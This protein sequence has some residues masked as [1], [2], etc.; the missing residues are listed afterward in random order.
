MKIQLASDL[1]LEFLGSRYPQAVADERIIGHP[2]RD[3]L[4]LAGDIHVGTK[5]DLLI[6]HELQYSDVLYITGNHE[7]YTQVLPEVI[8]AWRGPTTRRINTDA[9]EDGLKGRLHFLY[10]EQVILGGVRFL[11]GTLW[12]D[13]QGGNPVVMLQIERMLNDY[14]LIKIKKGNFAAGEE[15]IIFSAVNALY[16]H[17]E[18][19]RFLEAKLAEKFDGPTVVVTHHAP[20]RA[21]TDPKYR[22]VH[23]G[24]YS[25][26][27]NLILDTQPEYWLHG[28]VHSTANY[29][30]ENTRVR[31]NPRGYPEH[32]GHG[33]KMKPGQLVPDFD[34]KL[35]LEINNEG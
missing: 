16:E 11:G 18:T 34:P 9:E 32:M 31:C 19:R 13:F 12:T 27:V 21:S 29:S 6:M 7:G 22:N 2:E 3:L 1:H 30:I 24:D 35:I 23:G 10:N 5:A 33:G 20:A 26:L 17:K 8:T 4:I 25:D 14:R 15:D 28:H